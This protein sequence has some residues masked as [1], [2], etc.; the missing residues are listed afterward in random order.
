MKPFLNVPFLP[1]EGY[2]E[3]L[4]YCAPDLDS[5]H[6]SLLHSPP[7]DSRINIHPPGDQEKI[8]AGLERLPG[9]RK[10][11]LLNSRFYSPD[12]LTRPEK[13]K[14]LIQILDQYLARGVIDGIVYCDH[15]LLQLLADKA[16]TIAAR[17]EAVP[18]VNIML[19]TCD[20]IEAQLAYVDETGFM[21]PGKIILDRSLNRNL[22]ELAN[23][24]LKIHRHFPALKLEVLANEGCLPYCPFKLSHDAYIALGNLN[25]RDQ[26]HL[27][28]C[29]LGC[30]RLIDQKPH[31]LLLSPFIRPEDIDLFLY[32]IDTIKLCGR[33]LG[34]DFLMNA[35]RAYRLRRYDG[36]LLDLMDAL[37]WLAG[38]LHVNNRMLSFDFANMLS[39][40]DKRCQQCG[41]CKELFDSIAHPQPLT[42]KNHQA[43]SQ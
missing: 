4:T 1:E 39:Q 38:R 16:P 23:I 21:M 15:Y 32:H 27:L 29:D 19:D 2:V 35:I 22:D 31:K 34:S 11:A 42:I 25:G 43:T 6:F 41:F 13:I 33:T 40:C 36:N 18:G 3:F 5:V 14:P 24:A 8:L 9:V 7:L 12:L 28:N 26:T 30:M 20:K 10:Y 17:L 37:S